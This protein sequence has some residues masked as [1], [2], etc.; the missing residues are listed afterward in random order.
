MPTITGTIRDTQGNAIP[1]AQVTL[2]YTRELVGYEGGAVAQNVRVFT[3]NGSGV[4]T[5]AGV[6]P[7]YY[8]ITVS[9]PKSSETET[10]RVLVRGIGTA[11]AVDAMSL[12]A[13]L[14][15]STIGEITP[16]ILQEAIDAA[17]QAIAFGKVYT[18]TDAQMA[19]ILIDS[20]VEIIIRSPLA[21]GQVAPITPM[22]TW[23]RRNSSPGSDPYFVTA[24]GAQWTQ[25]A[26]RE[27]DVVSILGSAIEALGLE[28]GS[29]NGFASRA[30]AVTW[31]GSN[32]PPVGTVIRFD[33]VAVRYIGSGTVIA[34]MA[35]WVPDGD[36]RLEHFG[37]SAGASAANNWA[38]WQAAYDASDVLHF[39]PGFYNFGDNRLEI[40][41]NNFRIY[42]ARNNRTHLQFSAS[43]NGMRVSPPSPGTATGFINGFQMYDVALV[44][45][46]V[47]ATGLGLEI[48]M[49]NGPVVERV[50]VQGFKNGWR[51]AGG[52]GGRFLGV[53]GF[54]PT[55]S[56]IADVSDTY[57]LNIAPHIRDDLSASPAYTH[58]FDLVNF[59][60]GTDKNC[61]HTI[62]IGSG[63][64]IQFAQGFV[65][66]GRTSNLYLEP[67]A[68]AP[69]GN[70]T[71]T[72]TGQIY[73]DGVSQSTGTNYGVLFGTTAFTGRVTNL[74]VSS[75]TF[76]GNYQKSAIYSRANSLIGLFVDGA[77]L[78]GCDERVIDI[79][80]VT[81]SSGSRIVIGGGTTIR[82]GTLGGAKIVGG[83]VI[84]VTGCAFSD[85]AGADG[86]LY[87]GG[88][89]SELVVQGNSYAGNSADF[90]NAG[91]LRPRSDVIT[92]TFTPTIEFGG[93][94][95]GVTYST[96]QG[97]YTIIGD[98][99]IGSLRIIL[100]SKGTST[101]NLRLRTNLASA[102]NALDKTAVSIELSAIASGTAERFMSS[103]VPGSTSYFDIHRMGVSDGVVLL[104]DA[105]IN[106]NTSIQIAF[107][108][109]IAT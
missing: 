46:G 50:S 1:G 104:T 10:A 81:G 64:G 68:D 8:A 86:A 77:N 6:V 47:T 49:A 12:E 34:D 67:E 100:T 36:V 2:T 96:Q 83:R 52:Q 75:G 28:L 107:Q 42:G 57:V 78:S 95:V 58:S 101:G 30:A 91:T 80:G 108:W 40:T 73:F 14:A 41:K 23:W 87:V 85:N 31:V 53:S 59:S 92:G 70:I 15:D 63:D 99:L 16:T 105:N 69:A 60:G 37:G 44:G 22:I 82:N 20:G 11:L 93:A 102:L 13:F 66:F 7:G 19:A 25:T 55:G 72:N 74:R 62:R 71:A 106:N 33:G 17:A 97:N 45:A 48:I 94:S 38:A 39:G 18:E 56:V 89:I 26:L 61:E 4:V 5:M 35:G 90:T 84:Q 79:E 54:A 103:T 24:G 29:Y 51:V 65:N 109:R 32:T 21:T 88:T 76:I 3:A 27:Q 43:A 98:R 9:M